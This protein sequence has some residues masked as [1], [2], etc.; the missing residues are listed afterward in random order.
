[1]YSS[2]ERERETEG[3]V[4][5]G[6]TEKEIERDNERER[7]RRERERE[8]ISLSFVPTLICSSLRIVGKPRIGVTSCL[9]CFYRLIDIWIESPFL[10]KVI[11][12]CR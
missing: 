9:L 3:S 12:L 2:R 6:D 7:K 11:P 4:I 10:V 8:T 1:M 5:D